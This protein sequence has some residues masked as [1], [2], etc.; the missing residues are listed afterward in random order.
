MRES[1]GY[2]GHKDPLVRDNSTIKI[3]LTLKEAA[4]EDLDIT[5]FGQAFGE[6]LYESNS[7]GNNAKLY[8]YK[9]REDQESKKLK[10]VLFNEEQRRKKR[11]LGFDRE[12]VRAL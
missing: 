11:K 10:E 8:E 5:V 7:K 6:Y 12:A 2:T 3:E 9:L 4:A 1:R